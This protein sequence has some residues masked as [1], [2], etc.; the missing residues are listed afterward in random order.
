MHTSYK[1]TG[2]PC[3][4]EKESE[5]FSSVWAYFE[6]GTVGRQQ[7]QQQQ[8]GLRSLNLYS[9]IAISIISKPP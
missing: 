5:T 3:I 8:G 1:L 7:Q 2:V 6:V 9:D 4:K